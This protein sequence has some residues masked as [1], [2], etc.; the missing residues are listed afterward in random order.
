MIPHSARARGFVM[1]TMLCCLPILVGFLGLAIDTSYLEWVKTRL[2]TAADAAAMGGVQEFRMNGAGSVVS[3]ARNDAGLN[4][5]TN[6]Q[7][8][9]SVTVNNPPASGYSTSDPSAVEV[10]VA[11]K[12]SPFFMSAVGASAVSLQARAVAHQA[13]GTVCIVA[14]DAAASGAFTASNGSNVQSACGIMVDSSS[15]SAFTVSGGTTVKASTIWVT[16]NSSVTGGSSATP[17]PSVGIPSMSDPL[18]NVA[19][20]AVG[21]CN[22]TNTVVGGGLTKTL[23]PGVYCNGISLGNGAHITFAPAGTYILKGGGLSIAGGV[24]ATGSGVT[25]YNTAGGGY[26][27]QPFNFSNGATVTLS[28]PTT[29]PLAGILLFQDRSIVSSAVN[30]FLGGTTN[31]LNG[32]LYFST[33]PVSYSGGTNVAG[34]YSIIV[35]RTINFQGGCKVNNDYSSLPG[36]SPVKGNATLSE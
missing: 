22:Y 4:G 30:Q 2:Q 1:V 11:Q 32:A 8:G 18:A 6:G 14:L 27:Y 36:G 31:T 5:F 29:G 7:N 12:V 19:A 17:T 10:I 26:S 25:F 33:T 15:A 9:V 35:S 21:A 34:S 23:P 3:A 13:S 28:A 16:G 20:P 24:T